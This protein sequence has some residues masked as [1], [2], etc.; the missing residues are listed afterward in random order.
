[1]FGM[2]SA[3]ALSAREIALKQGPFRSGASAG[4]FPFTT[5]LSQGVPDNPQ[6]TPSAP[7]SRPQASI[8]AALTLLALAGLAS[9]APISGVAQI[10][11][12]PIILCSISLIVF[13]VIAT[14]LRPAG[15]RTSLDGAP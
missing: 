15:R 1:M 14:R 5:F 6:Q 7:D 10:A 4:A 3:S 11:F 2:H 9:R 8:L 13:G 12:A